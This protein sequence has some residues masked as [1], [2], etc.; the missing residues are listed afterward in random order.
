MRLNWLGLS[1]EKLKKELPSISLRFK[2]INC[3]VSVG[4]HLVHMYTV[5]QEP[6]QVDVSRQLYLVCVHYVPGTST[7]GSL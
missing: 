6:V 2:K 7:G 1:E 5:F 3:L 4:T